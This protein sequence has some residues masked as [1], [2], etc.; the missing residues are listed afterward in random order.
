ML[1]SGRVGS[2]DKLEPGDTKFRLEI[3]VAVSQPLPL[4]LK[5][6]KGQGATGLL[7]GSP[8][9]YDDYTEFDEFGGQR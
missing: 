2:I 4:K 8:N 7:T 6:F 1:S 3:S 5:N 9:P